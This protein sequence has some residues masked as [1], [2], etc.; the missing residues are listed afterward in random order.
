MQLRAGVLR[1]D[2][3]PRPHAGTACRNH[4][5]GLVLDFT[6]SSIGKPAQA[7]ASAQLERHAMRRYAFL[8]GTDESSMRQVYESLRAKAEPEVV[9]CGVP[10]QGFL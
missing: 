1:C 4:I 3:T 2:G 5:R 10:E 6:A 8:G 7:R 9:L